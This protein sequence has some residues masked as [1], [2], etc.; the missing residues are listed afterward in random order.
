VCPSTCTNPCRPRRANASPT[1]TSTLQSPPSTNGACPA[2]TSGPS[3]SARRRAW[4]TSASWLRTRPEAG[5]PSSTY[6]PA[7]T[8]PASIAP[9]LSRCSCKPASRS[10]SGAFAQ[11]G[12][13]PGCGGRSP[14][15]DGADSI[16]ITPSSLTRCCPTSSYWWIDQR[17]TATGGVELDHVPVAL[18][19]EDVA[20]RRRGDLRRVA[21]I[22][23]P[24]GALWRRAAKM[25]ACKIALRSAWH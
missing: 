19:L 7:S 21:R 18:P 25:A 3:R 11:P 8:T 15:F 9:A 5:S 13:L 24:A 22:R 17:K 4:L 14:R 2:S 1:P 20:G 6:L 16:A 10:A 23:R 12:T